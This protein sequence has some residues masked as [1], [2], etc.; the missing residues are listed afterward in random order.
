MKALFLSEDG[1]EDTELLCPL[2]RLLEE[3]IEADVAAIKKGLI[4]GK[5]GYQ[6]MAE[7]T[8]KDILPQEYG[9]LVLAGGNAPEK[10]RLAESA[11][12]IARHF[13]DEDK[14]VASICHGAQILISAGRLDGR[15][16]TAWRGIRDDLAAA[17]ANVVDEE[18]VVDGNWISSRQPQDLPAFNRA[19]MKTIRE[20]GGRE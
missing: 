20:R 16:G 17:G 14:P 2:Y 10:A 7:K 3:G 6:V 12:K 13:M 19:I 4:T 5:H 15:T 1:F 11:L 18:V 8:F 9:L